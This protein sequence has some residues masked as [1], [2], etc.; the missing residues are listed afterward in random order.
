MKKYENFRSFK[1]RRTMFRKNSEID[2]LVKVFNKTWNYSSI[3]ESN[4]SYC[5]GQVISNKNDEI[6]FLHQ[7]WLKS[8]FSHRA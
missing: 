4:F 8:K 3:N 2:N 7:Q 5:L 1:I 6:S